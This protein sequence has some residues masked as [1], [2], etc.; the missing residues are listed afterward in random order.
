MSQIHINEII[1]NRLERIENKVDGLIEFKWQII[2][3]TV[4]IS[5]LLTIGFQVATLF[6]YKP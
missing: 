3:G 5:V 1:L 6:I 4:L 2:G